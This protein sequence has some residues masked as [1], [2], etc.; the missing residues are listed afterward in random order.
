[1]YKFL[2]NIVSI[3]LVSFY[4]FPIEFLA[5]PG[6]NTKMVLAFWGLLIFGKELAQ[7]RNA[8]MDK[9]FFVLSLWA[10]GISLIS[11]VT[12]TVNNTPDSSFLTYFVSMWVWM[13]GAYAVIKWLNVTY[14]YVNV[15]LIC[16]CLIAVCVMQCLVAWGKVLYPPLQDVVD[17]LIGGEAFMGNTKGARLSGIGASLDVAGL[18]FSAV[19]VMIGY[20]LSKTQKM[21]QMQLLGYLF[22]FLVITVIGNMMS[23]TTTLGVGIALAYWIYS[24]CFKP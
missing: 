15:R 16:N 11:L 6:V 10:L 24:S 17:Q 18:R 4:F 2:I 3:I 12:M 5:F 23:R 21:K 20:I 22:S 14:G 19:I 13:G 1:M 8:G 7:K 9:D